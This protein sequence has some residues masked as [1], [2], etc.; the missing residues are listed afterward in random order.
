MYNM[1]IRNHNNREMNLLNDRFFDSF[2]R[3]DPFFDA[4]AFRVDVQEN[5]DAY[6]LSAELP[7]M[8]Q[9][10]I[11]IVAQ[12]GVLTISANMNN[13][14]KS[15]KN[16]YLYTE[17]RTG[18][19]RRSFNLEGIREDAITARYED[20]ILTLHLPKVKPEEEKPQVRRIAIAGPSVQANAPEQENA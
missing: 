4:P 11:D 17:R 16:G 10:Q 20:G 15:D 6:E 2:F 18:T 3:M 8:K 14:R 5:A 19:F 9:D 13:E 12:D 7:G 1:M